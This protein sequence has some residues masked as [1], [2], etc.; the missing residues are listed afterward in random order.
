MKNYLKHVCKIGQG[1]EC[2]KYLVAGSK[3]FE[4]MRIEPANKSIIDKNWARTK[5]V[6]QGDNCMGQEDLHLAKTYNECILGEKD[7]GKDGFVALVK[8]AGINEPKK[9]TFSKLYLHDRYK[10]LEV[11]DKFDVVVVEKDF[12][13]AILIL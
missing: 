12:I 4:C 6:A 13:K 11:G 2:C 10:D 8:I 1:A 3:G 7:S 5:H 9:I